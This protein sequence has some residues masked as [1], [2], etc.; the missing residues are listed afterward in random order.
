VIAWSRVAGIALGEYGEPVVL[1]T[2]DSV[3]DMK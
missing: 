1:F 3:P 2:A